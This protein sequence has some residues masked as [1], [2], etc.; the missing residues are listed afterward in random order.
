M[1]FSNLE[2]STLSIYKES[3]DFISI[4][5][6][7]IDNNSKFRYCNNSFIELF[8]MDPRKPLLCSPK[9]TIERITLNS[10]IHENNYSKR[11]LGTLNKENGQKVNLIVVNSLLYDHLGDFIGNLTIIDPNIQEDFTSISTDK[12]MKMKDVILDISNSIMEYE[13]INELLTFILDKV[14]E[15]MDNAQMGCILQRDSY[16]YMHIVVSKGYIDNGSFKFK[17]KDS[18]QYAMTKGKMDK[19]L[20]I[21]DIERLNGNIELKAMLYNDKGQTAKSTLSAPIIVDGEL[22]GMFNVDSSLNNVFDENDIA[23]MEYLRLQIS[24]AIKR[25]MIFEKT[26]HLSRHDKLTGITNRRHFEELMRFVIDKARRYNERFS[27]AMLDINDFK[28][29]ND[30]YGHISGDEMLKKFTSFIKANI[31]ESDLFARFGGDEFIIV[32]FEIDKSGI[33]DKLKEMVQKFL[34]SPLTYENCSIF[35][36]FSY[37]VCEFPVDSTD[38]DGI[39]KIADERMYLNKSLYKT[40]MHVKCKKDR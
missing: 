15:V 37:G 2:H 35:C 3:L 4:P 9:E 34:H 39:V 32:F 6:C 1:A 20:I 18:F 16:D 5:V 22:F 29:V 19:T 8:D 27:L 31:R 24:N 17:Y 38:I 33:E 25:H 7:I 40:T 12:F 11:H 30:I 23:L 26:V 21:N 13:S 10:L 36:S 28:S 14:I